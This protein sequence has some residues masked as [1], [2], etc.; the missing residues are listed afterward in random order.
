MAQGSLL[1]HEEVQVRGFKCYLCNNTS[2]VRSNFKFTQDHLAYCVSEEKCA[3]RVGEMEKSRS[4]A[5][6]NSERSH[7]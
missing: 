1:R 7:Q 6:E 5:E 2:L 3:E 4:A